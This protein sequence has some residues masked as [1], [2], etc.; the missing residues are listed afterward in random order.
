MQ[1]EPRKSSLPTP[2][3]RAPS[4]TLFWIARLSAR[5]SA[6]RVSFARIPPTRAAARKIASG[7][8]LAIHLSVGSCRRRSRS[9]RSTV[10]TSQ[11]SLARR[12]TS[13]RPTIP[14]WPAIHTRLPC[15]GKRASVGKVRLLLGRRDEVLGHH[16][17][18]ELS[19]VGFV[20]PSEAL[21][22]L[23][24]VAPQNLDFGRPE[25]ARIDL[26][27]HTAIL[28]VHAL[29]VAVRAPPGDLDSDLSESV[30]REIADERRLAG[31]QHIV[32]RL[33]LLQHEPHAADVLAGVAPVA[34]RAEVAQ[35]EPVL[36][37]VVD[38]RDS[39]GDLARD[40]RFAAHRALVVEQDAVRG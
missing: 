19:P 15:S 29:F 24:G 4:I 3:R 7:R 16:L 30:R 10:S 5:N 11:S 17:L 28:G 33:V 2:A 32:V 38:G 31:R 18:A 27:E 14:R 39:A 12:R 37:P 40:E 35:V 25:V 20:R 6:G 36:Q 9:T 13:A 8:A 21:A 22:R 1:L 23:R 26:D 34:P